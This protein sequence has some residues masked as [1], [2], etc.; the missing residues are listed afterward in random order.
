M[1]IKRV[2]VLGAGVMGSGIAAHVA[3]AGIPVTLLDIVAPDGEPRSAI[4]GGAVTKM[5]KTEPA[6][7]MSPANARLVSVGNLDD[8]LGKLEH[9]DWIVEAIVERLDIKRDLYKKVDTV[10]KPGSV[11][12]SNTSTI[13]LN[14]LIEGMSPEF[15]RDFMITHFFNPPRYMRLLEV[16]KGENTRDDAFDAIRSFCDHQLG[17]GVVTCNDTPG[18]IGNRIGVFWMQCAVN[19]A[20]SLGLTVEEADAVGG[21][22]MGIPKTGVFGLL[23]LVGIDLMP[24]VMSSMESLLPADDAMREHAEIPPLL[25]KMIADGY[26]GRKGKGGFYRLQR[27]GAKR[28]KQAIDLATGE[29]RDVEK[30][31]LDSLQTSKKEGLR[32]LAEHSDRGGEFAWRVLSQTLSYAASLVPEITDEIVAVD[33][34]MR[35]GFNWQHGPF[36]LIDIVGA[37][38]LAARLETEQR[39]VPSLLARARERDGF[40]RVQAKGREFLA[41]AGDYSPVARADGV[42]MLEDIKDVSKPI[43]SN[44]SASLWDLGDGVVCL[45]FHSKMNAID[46]DIM[47]MIRKAVT[48]VSEHYDALVVY[49]EGANFSV[50]VN[51][52]HALFAVNI[53]AWEQIEALVKEGQDTYAALKYAPFPV[54]GAPSGMALGGGCEVLLH[55]DAIVAHAE[56]YMGLVEVG[57]GLLP[58]WGGCKEMLRRWQ[59]TSDVPGGP[60]PPV[61]KA[62]ET[63]SL[64]QVSKS[65]EQAR[66][67]L[68]LSAD[69][70]V[71]MNRE[72]LL[73]SA[74]AHALKLATDYRAPEPG[75][76]VLPGPAARAALN[77]AVDGF[78]KQ[79]KAT[80]HD[81]VVG[82]ALATVLS[83]AETDL[84]ESLT[85]DDVLALER[86]EFMRLVRT[87]ATIA[88]VE[89]TL[90]TGKPLRN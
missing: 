88:R 15:Q 36:E 52:G 43:E 47:A 45:E 48:L 58:G 84:T 39:P 22:P 90:N 72:R 8:D 74:K 75:T 79:G 73:A 16:V 83:G 53:A 17:K 3:N 1:E 38:W 86:R 59:E 24:H 21:K 56:T 7:F 54:V 31:T 65:A 89:H 6:A 9:V 34:A 4:A 71:V 11:V 66:S 82:D 55:C 78:R 37:D 10:R 41:M 18:F 5:L 81:A 61:M 32:A 28:V 60:M 26:T 70:H 44:A 76:M 64:A 33:E 25:Q 69:D 68:F 12:S 42:V 13:P 14:S 30:A 40:Y 23:D 77:M 35:L 87:P 51:L 20:M 2:A 67:L 50:G 80:A 63:I 49:N 57:V 85:E 46:P 27:D 62:F 29:Y 19:E